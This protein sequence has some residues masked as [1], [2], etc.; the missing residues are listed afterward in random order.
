[1]VAAIVDLAYAFLEQPSVLPLVGDPKQ[2]S[3]HKFDGRLRNMPGLRPY[4]RAQE[5]DDRLVLCLRCPIREALAQELSILLLDF[6][7]LH[8]LE[9]V[10]DGHID[11][12]RSSARHFTLYERYTLDDAT[13]ADATATRRVVAEITAD[14]EASLNLV[15]AITTF[16]NPFGGPISS[17]V[18]RSLPFIQQLG[19]IAAAG[20]L[21]CCLWG[22][23]EF[24]E[25]QLNPEVGQVPRTH[26]TV[27]V[28]AYFSYANTVTSALAVDGVTEEDA[29]EAGH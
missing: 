5:G 6:V 11:L 2:H 21:L 22:A 1:L 14:S 23:I 3:P 7:W 10:T 18:F 27:N 28:R 20:Q 19:L 15:W 25:R 17:S 8:E 16:E 13:R 4:F 26:P 24:I 29:I 12:F 9:H